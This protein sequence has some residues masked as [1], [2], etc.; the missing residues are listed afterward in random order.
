MSEASFPET[1]VTSVRVSKLP[2]VAMSGMHKFVERVVTNNDLQPDPDKPGKFIDEEAMV[3]QGLQRVFLQELGVDIRPYLTYKVGVGYQYDEE[4]A[5]H[6]VLTTPPAATNERV[7]LAPSADFT[8]NPC[9]T[10]EHHAV[11]ES[12]VAWLGNNR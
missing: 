4:G 7:K 1:Q 11:L 6:I 2:M 3:S 5:G 9:V 8:P 12:L 10:V